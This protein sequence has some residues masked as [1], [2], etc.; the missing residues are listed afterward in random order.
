MIHLKVSNSIPLSE[1]KV[2]AKVMAA[3]QEMTVEG[4]NDMPSGTVRPF[5]C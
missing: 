1:C 4:E 2:Y 3:Q 5:C